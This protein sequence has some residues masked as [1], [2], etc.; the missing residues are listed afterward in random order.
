MLARLCSAILRELHLKGILAQI[1]VV[2]YNFGGRVEAG[3][4]DWPIERMP[5]NTRIPTGSL[6]VMLIR[7]RC[8][9]SRISRTRSRTCARQQTCNG[10]L[11]FSMKQLIY[12]VLTNK[13]SSSHYLGDLRSPYISCNAA[14]YPGVTSYGPTF[15]P[16][17]DATFLD[18]NRSVL[19]PDYRESMK[20]IVLKQA[21][22]DSPQV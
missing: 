9:Q 19:E 7:S 12:S 17:H 22:S 6:A 21:D 1:L 10:S 13:D 18:I 5:K 14:V 15:E 8:P 4:E 2:S 3:S 11:S 20:E 16:T